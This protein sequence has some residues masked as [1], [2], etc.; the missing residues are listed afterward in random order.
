MQNYIEQQQTV[1][2]L[3]EYYLGPSK[4]NSYLP[5]QDFDQV[6]N[7][8][9]GPLDRSTRRSSSFTNAV[10]NSVRMSKPDFQRAVQN[11]NQRSQ[12]SFPTHFSETH[13]AYDH[14]LGYD[15]SI[16]NRRNSSYVLRTSAQQNIMDKRDPN[17]DTS[18]EYDSHY[19]NMYNQNLYP[20]NNKV[21]VKKSS[22]GNQQQVVQERDDFT[23]NLKQQNQNIKGKNWQDKEQDRVGMKENRW[24]QGA[25]NRPSS[26]D[27]NNS[28][29]NWSGVNV[30]PSV[31]RVNEPKPKSKVQ[32]YKK[33]SEMFKR[34]KEAFD[35]GM[36]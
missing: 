1:K 7:S 26:V 29:S 18:G 23:G 9:E 36:K 14:D 25:G 31:E 10:H 2:P 16:E 8:R 19:G 21:L 35:Q 4:S 30:K 5:P 24:N 15:N 34:Q 13:S 17:Y 12:K 32:N 33:Y 20:N 22:F 27:P 6:Q 28:N 11:E 3:Q